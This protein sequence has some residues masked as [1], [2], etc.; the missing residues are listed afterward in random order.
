MGGGISK[1]DVLE[2]TKPTP[3]PSIIYQAR[4]EGNNYF[5]ILIHFNFN[6]LQL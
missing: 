2:E 1:T 3:S 4:K 5:E 6:I